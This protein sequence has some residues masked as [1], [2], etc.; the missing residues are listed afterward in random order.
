MKDA[1]DGGVESRTNRAWVKESPCMVVRIRV[2]FGSLTQGKGGGS[3]IDSDQ[4]CSALLVAE[5]KKIGI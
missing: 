4:P 1:R 2:G 3:G 5:K